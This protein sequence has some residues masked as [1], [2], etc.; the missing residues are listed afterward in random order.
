MGGRGQQASARCGRGELNRASQ[1]NGENAPVRC[2]LLTQLPSR[3]T[4][5]TPSYWALVQL[6]TLSAEPF[7][8]RISSQFGQPSRRK[9]VDDSRSE[10]RRQARWRLLLED[11]AAADG[12]MA[13]AE[14]AGGGSGAGFGSSGGV[15]RRRGRR[16][17]LRSRSS[18]TGRGRGWST[19][20]R[21]I[22]AI[23]AA[24]GA[25]GGRRFRP[26]PAFASPTEL[27]SRNVDLPSLGWPA[28]S[29]QPAPT[30]GPDISP[31]FSSH[32]SA[33]WIR[34][35]TSRRRFGRW[36]HCRRRT[37]QPSLRPSSAPGSRPPS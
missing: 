10:H 37:C 22:G 8:R 28:L 30:T 29:P 27:S 6:V 18:R 34:R 9:S 13:A 2:H 21:A 33:A 24:G 3:T 14:G 1:R 35:T 19:S 32:S 26:A 36:P 4:A 5:I 25:V 12:G 16:W 20:V 7:M 11:G 15:A 31:S 17:W 23:G